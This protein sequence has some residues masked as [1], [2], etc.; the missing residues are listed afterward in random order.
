MYIAKLNSNFNLN[1]NWV[2]YS[3]NF[4][5]FSPT[6]PTTRTSSDNSTITSISTSTELKISV[7]TST[8][9]TKL[10]LSLAQRSPSLFYLYLPSPNNPAR[11]RGW[12]TIE[13]RRN[14][15]G[16]T[17][18]GG[19]KNVK[20]ELL[21]EVRGERGQEHIYEGPTCYQD[22]FIAL[23]WSKCSKKWNDYKKI[24]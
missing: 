4:V 24:V 18:R 20:L 10:N 22:F 2:E 23:R 9:Q 1:Y 21:V 3:I 5:F 19:L 13:R 7:T 14:K 12:G 6:R 15:L 11:P 8:T 17:V 16:I